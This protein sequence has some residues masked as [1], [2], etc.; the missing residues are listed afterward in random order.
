MDVIWQVLNIPAVLTFMCILSWLTTNY[1]GIDMILN[2]INCLAKAAIFGGISGQIIT[3]WTPREF[4]PYVTAFIFLVTYIN[5]LLKFFLNLRAKQSNDAKNSI[6]E[7][8]DKIKDLFLIFDRLS[9]SYTAHNVIENTGK[10]IET[11]EP[12]TL[13]S[14]VKLIDNNLNQ[15]DANILTYYKEIVNALT[16]SE[17]LDKIKGIYIHDSTKGYVMLINP[18]ST[19][20]HV[21]SIKIGGTSN[22]RF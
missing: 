14:V 18:E 2:P 6:D 16:K 9:I 8:L 1:S 15:L 20:Q 19:F 13:Q 12:F 17:H 5:V 11:T 3:N 10:V 4:H 22:L 7:F 21:L